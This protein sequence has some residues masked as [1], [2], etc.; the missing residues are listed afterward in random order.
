MRR[1]FPGS[2]YY[3]GSAPSQP[4]Q[5]SVRS[6]TLRAGGPAGWQGPDGSRAHCDSLDGGGARL[7]PCGITTTTPQHFAVVSRPTVLSGPG[8][9]RR[10]PVG[11]HR[12]GPYPPDLSR[13]KMKGRKRRF[14]SYSFPSRSPDP[15]HLAVLTRPGFVRAASRPHRHHPDQTALSSTVL[16]RQ[17]Q[18]RRSP[19]SVRINSASRRTGRSFRT[20]SRMPCG[21][22]SRTSPVSSATQAPSRISP[23]DARPRLP[24]GD[25]RQGGRKGA[26]LVRR[27]RSSS[28]PYSSRR[29]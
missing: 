21:Q 27:L 17:D 23:G 10:Y 5:R 22:P 25:D 3:D 18:R 4:G 26:A 6:A 1:A 19:T 11:A 2:E 8:V 7:C 16:L 12:P 28:S 24:R 29:S 13:C 15:H 14:L 9:T 20:I